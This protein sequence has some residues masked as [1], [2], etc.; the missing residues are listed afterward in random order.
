ME[1]LKSEPANSIVQGELKRVNSLLGK[2]KSELPDIATSDPTAT[3]RRRVPIAIVDPP[4]SNPPNSHLTPLA[5]NSISNPTSQILP[6][7]KPTTEILQPVSSRS[8]KSQPHVLSSPPLPTAKL[9]PSTKVDETRTFKGA[10]RARENAK[11][12]RVGGGIFRASGDS[13][14]FPIRGEPPPKSNVTDPLPPTTRI[15]TRANETE[16]MSPSLANPI[17]RA[18]MTLFEF[19]K[20]WR[21]TSVIHDRWAL[22]TTILPVDLPILFKSSLEPTLL[23]DILQVFE[24]LVDDEKRRP[25]LQE[26]MENFARVPRFGTI[27]LFLSRKEKDTVERVWARLGIKKDAIDPIWGTHF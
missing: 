4:T 20:S 17:P 27:A 2:I 12:S 26:Y 6:P 25:L 11:P 7:A 10:R 21:S 8:L 22:I 18:S 16:G 3:K 1:A 13:T 24:V 19:S 14:I 5:I 15:D 9:P 23:V